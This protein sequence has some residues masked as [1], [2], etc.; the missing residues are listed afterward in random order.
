MSMLE[1]LP[2][3]LQQQ[4]AG[5]GGALLGNLLAISQTNDTGTTTTA[6][7]PATDTGD[8]LVLLAGHANDTTSTTATTP[9]GW[10][11][12]ASSAMASGFNGTVYQFSKAISSGAGSTTQ[13]IVWSA[14]ADAQMI[15]IHFRGQATSGAPNDFVIGNNNNSANPTNQA[16]A[17]N[18]GWADAS[19]ILLSW[20]FSN[21]QS[22]S[23]SSTISGVPS[24]MTSVFDGSHDATYLIRIN[25]SAEE[26]ASTPTSGTWALS[27]W[28]VGNDQ[29]SMRCSCRVGA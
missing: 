25:V 4:G 23:S 26:R 22:D 16:V 7:I 14:S 5:V 1:T 8:L 10:S 12:N 3:I 11:L 6:N 9:S 24:G 21:D 13:D 19:D 15:V 29:D 27:N 28:D 2:G 20:V 18:V 17:V